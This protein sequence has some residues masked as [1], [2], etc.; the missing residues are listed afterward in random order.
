ML[1]TTPTMPGSRCCLQ[2]GLLDWSKGPTDH[3]RTIAPTACLLLLL[4]RRR[5]L[6]LLRRLLLRRLTL[7]LIKT[8]Y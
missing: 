4:R 1:G 2:Q 6:L 8:W 3:L 7:T 5:L